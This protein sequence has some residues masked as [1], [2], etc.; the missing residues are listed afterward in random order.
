MTRM[1]GDVNGNGVSEAV[2]ITND[3]VYV[4][5]LEGLGFSSPV[6]WTSDFATDNGWDATKHIFKLID[7]NGNGKQDLVAFG[8]DGVY[9]A[10][11]NGRSFEA[12]TKVSD[13]FGLESVIEEGND[14][15]FED[16]LNGDWVTNRLLGD[17]NGDGLADIIVYGNDAIYVALQ[18]EDGSFE[19]QIKWLD[20]LEGDHEDFRGWTNERYLKEVHDMTNNG[21]ADLVNIGNRDLFVAHSTGERFEHLN[22]VTHY[23]IQNR[24]DEIL[25]GWN[26][27][28]YNVGWES[29]SHFRLFGDVTGNGQLDMVGFGDEFVVVSENQ[30]P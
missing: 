23:S 7:F 30:N 12:K 9:V 26:S 14:A 28:V 16:D 4:A 13:N 18:N 22:G 21:R 19:N 2:A 1:V 5:K 25:E 29:Q 27:F 10:Y 8:D 24:T 15:T 11:S 6:Q 3:G 20:S 17:V